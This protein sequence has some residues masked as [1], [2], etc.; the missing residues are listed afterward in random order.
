MSLHTGHK[1]LFSSDTHSRG[2][3]DPLGRRRGFC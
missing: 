2:L 3:D 1:L